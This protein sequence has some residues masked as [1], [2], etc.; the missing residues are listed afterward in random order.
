[1]NQKKYII[2]F[3]IVFT[4]LFLLGYSYTSQKNGG[5]Y[6]DENG[7]YR[8]K[9][10]KISQSEWSSVNPENSGFQ[11]P[12]ELL[13]E[14]DRSVESIA[15]YIGNEDWI[16]Y[17]EIY[18]ETE[19]D[20]IIDIKFNYGISRAIG[21]VHMDPTIR[22]L[23]RLSREAFEAGRAPVAHEV[24][25]LVSPKFSAYSLSEGLACYAHNRFASN[26]KYTEGIH[27]AIKEYMTEEYSYVLDNIG[28]NDKDVFDV[29]FSYKEERW[30]F[31]VYSH[32]FTQYIID[33]YGL[34][35]YMAL[36]A[37]ECTKDDYEQLFGTNR[38]ILIQEWV[39][40]VKAY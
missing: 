12:A 22:P 33:T 23:I 30:I 1:M 7:Y 26:P 36:Y 4:A 32:S 18:N 37:S 28:I 17:F 27:K 35:S 15:S 2:G 3:L 24:T 34:D 8:S 5:V 19:E 14:V 16:E 38:E 40:F 29:Y 20:L 39:S 10:A 25:H 6:L 13:L 31:Y 11:T 9:Y 21:G